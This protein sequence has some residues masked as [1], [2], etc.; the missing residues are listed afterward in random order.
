MKNTKHSCKEFC[1]MEQNWSKKVERRRVCHTS[2]QGTSLNGELIPNQDVPP[3][4]GPA[5]TCEFSTLPAVAGWGHQSAV[6]G[7]QDDWA[8][9]WSDIILDPADDGDCLLTCSEQEDFDRWSRFFE[10]VTTMLAR[11]SKILT[12]QFQPWLWHRMLPSD[13]LSGLYVV[14]G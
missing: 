9:L 3:D 5:S 14:N 2:G 7:E 12:L 1:W 11:C 8:P 10:S 4:K 6:K 13:W